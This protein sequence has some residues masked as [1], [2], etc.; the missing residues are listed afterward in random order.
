MTPEKMKAWIDNAT[1]EQLLSKWRYEPI[2]SP[3]FAGELGK[4]YSD[5]MK[6]RREEISDEEKI[7]T[8]KKVGW[9]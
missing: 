8:S 1:Y 9:E 2:G 3:W 6:K 5:V 4:Y 7:A